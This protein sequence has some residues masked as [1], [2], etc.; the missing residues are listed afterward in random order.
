[1]GQN[2]MI[3]TLTTLP[4]LGRGE[5]TGGTRIWEKMEKTPSQELEKSDDEAF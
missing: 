3:L 2:R 4:R 1:M 5:M